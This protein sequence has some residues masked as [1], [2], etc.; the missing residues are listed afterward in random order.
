MF[1]YVYRYTSSVNRLES[2][3]NVCI[4]EEE[5]NGS[6][7]DIKQNIEGEEPQK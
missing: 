6:K 7:E 3:N 1:Y 4:W 5:N 2:Q